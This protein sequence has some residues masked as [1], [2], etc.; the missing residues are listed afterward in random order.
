M[1]GTLQLTC[2]TFPPHIN[3]YTA[4]AK[5]F[6][7]KNPGLSIKV[8]PVAAQAQYEAKIRAGFAAKDT[9]DLASVPGYDVMEFALAGTIAPLDPGATTPDRVKREWTPDYYLCR[10]TTAMSGHSVSPIPTATAGW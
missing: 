4:I 3:A 6:M 10:S 1:T 8:V 9:P 5:S 2:I 7:A